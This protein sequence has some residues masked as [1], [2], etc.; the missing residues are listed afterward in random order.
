MV[1]KARFEVN[2]EHLR[3]EASWTTMTLNAKR[4]AKELTYKQS[5]V[6][7]CLYYKIMKTTIILVGIYVDD[8]L[9]KSNNAKM[10]N[11]FLNK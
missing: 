7:M 4:E 2:K 1:E 6:Y 11:D 9:E 5:S 3:I 10:V 8:L